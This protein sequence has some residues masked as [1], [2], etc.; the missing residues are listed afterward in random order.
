MIGDKMGTLHLLDA[1]RKIVLDKKTIF[2]GQRIT[3][4]SS[5]SI[6]W[7]DTHLSTIAVIARGSPDIKII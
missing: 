1:S 7:L 3:D 4:I 2:E 6:P 5:A